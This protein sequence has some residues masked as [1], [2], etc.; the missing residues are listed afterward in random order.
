LNFS[1]I[2]ATCELNSDRKRENASFVRSLDSSTYRVSEKRQKY[3][4]NFFQNLPCN[5]VQTHL[6]SKIF[7]SCYFNLSHGF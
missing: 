6:R 4:R 7:N 2:I 5:V 3:E 1:C